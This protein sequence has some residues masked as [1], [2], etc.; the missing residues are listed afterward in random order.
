MTATT[1]E[2][3]NGSVIPALT[4]LLVTTR[5]PETRDYRAIGFLTHGDARGYCFTYLRRE[6]EREG[7]RPL[8]G[9]TRAVDA[10]FCSSEL[11]PIFAE[12]VISSR[13][14]DRAQ[15]MSA[16]GLPVDAAPF[17]VLVRSG[18]QRVGDTVELLPAPHVGSNGEISVTFLAHG[19][20]HLPEQAQDRI[21]RLTTGEELRLVAQ[22]DNPKDPRAQ[23]VTDTDAVTL[24]WL[25][26][27]LIPLAEGMATRT[28]TVER[29]NGPEVGFHFR[30]LVRLEGHW[31]AGV[32]P[33]EGPDWQTVDEPR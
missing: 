32:Q 11:F 6:R 25:P 30:L 28:L 17:E 33:F 15:S 21:S 3:V 18:G 1:I 16:L 9:L 8:P 27:P 19:V 14:P 13:R 5:D 7:F 24:G 31:S 22:P 20:R 29:A 2:R 12:R 23:I 10:T 26:A 4:R